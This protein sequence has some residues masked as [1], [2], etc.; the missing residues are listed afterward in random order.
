MEE[1]ARTDDWSLSRKS[2]YVLLIFILFLVNGALAYVFLHPH[3]KTLTVSF[4]NIGQGDSILIQGPT[5]VKMLVDGGPDRSV[6]RELGKKLVPW[7][8]TF[9][10]LVETHPDKD[11]I[12]GLGDVLERYRV[13]EYLDPGIPDSTAVSARVMHAVA[14][15]PG[16]THVIARRGM[17]IHLGGGAY[18]D[19]LFPD[20][21]E[22]TLKATNDGSVVLHIIYGTTSFMLTGD[23]PSPYEDYLVGIDG[24]DGELQSDVL[25]AGHHGSKYSSDSLWLAAVHPKTVVI[26]AGK[27]NTYGHPNPEAVARITHEGAYMLSTIDHGT[28]TFIS[29]G[30]VLTTHTE[31]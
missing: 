1:E 15:E 31:K 3:P 17:R 16:L 21:D 5:G 10:L 12:S 4:L 18:A 19:V 27:G 8:R 14:T 20:R 7:D 29:D 9:D 2:V 6:L 22:S 23:L 24:N 28:V 11:H 25:K 13:K 26:S 30:H